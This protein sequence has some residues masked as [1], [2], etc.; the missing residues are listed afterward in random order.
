[1]QKYTQPSTLASSLFVGMNVYPGLFISQK[2]TGVD[3]EEEL[4][5][6]VHS[7]VRQ[8]YFHGACRKAGFG[9]DAGQ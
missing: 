4:S 6:V 7:V 1:M 3:N 9:V 5:E 2:Y 8:Q